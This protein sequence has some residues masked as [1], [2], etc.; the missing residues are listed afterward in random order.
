PYVPVYDPAN[1]LGGYGI[2]TSVLDG[3]DATNPLI[4]PNLVDRKNRGFNN[5]LQLFG[6][7][8]ILDGLKFR[9]QLGATYNFNQNYT[10]NPMYAG[11]QLIT[12]DRISENYDYGLGYI[13]ENY[14][15]YNKR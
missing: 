9:S 5:Y 2:A 10:F 11:N 8:D 1:S 14:F 15:T 4:R 13:L 6:E 7:L 3:N 12:F